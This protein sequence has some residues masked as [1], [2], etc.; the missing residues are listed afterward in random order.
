MLI[1]AA[2]E[3]ELEFRKNLNDIQQKIEK[4]KQIERK[5]IANLLVLNNEII[6]K[7]NQVAE[8]FQSKTVI[9]YGKLGKGCNKILNYTSTK[10]KE[11][12]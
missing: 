12:F 7:L 4:P 3:A 11:L 6:D 1:E 5:K 9:I 2:D 10:A 8:S